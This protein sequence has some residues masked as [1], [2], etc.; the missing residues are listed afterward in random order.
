[1]EKDRSEPLP[2]D[3]GFRCGADGLRF[4]D[5]TERVRGERVSERF[6]QGIREQNTV[7]YYVGT[8]GE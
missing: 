4:D 3:A 7:G 6:G 5:S 1:M 2:V 8:D